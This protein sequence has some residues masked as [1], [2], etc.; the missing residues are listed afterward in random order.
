MFSPVVKSCFFP[1]Q[2]LSGSYNII[3]IYSIY[4]YSKSLVFD[5]AGKAKNIEQAV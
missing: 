5:L 2:I 1:L 4:I 3:Q